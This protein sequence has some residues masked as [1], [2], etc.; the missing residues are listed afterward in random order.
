MWSLFSELAV[1]L[2]LVLIVQQIRRLVQLLEHQSRVDLLTGALN[3]R[4]LFETLEQERSRAERYGLPMTVVFVDLDG[5]KE[6]NDFGWAT[7]EA[8]SSC[9]ASRGRLV[10]RFVTRISLLA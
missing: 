3:T 1:F 7:P 8:T 5:M 9:G 10:L 4:G 6:I 2:T